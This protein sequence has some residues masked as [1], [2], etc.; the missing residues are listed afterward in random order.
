MIQS[1]KKKL[2]DR[3]LIFGADANSIFQGVKKNSIDTS[4]EVQTLLCINSIV[5]NDSGALTQ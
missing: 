1:N 4:T 2:P 3:F 5:Q